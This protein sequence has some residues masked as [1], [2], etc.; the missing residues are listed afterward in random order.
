[1]NSESDGDDPVNYTHAYTA[2]NLFK[3]QFTVNGLIFYLLDFVLWEIFR[4]IC[5]SYILYQKG[6]IEIYASELPGEFN[7]RRE[8]LSQQMNRQPHVTKGRT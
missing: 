5:I 3:F 7:T 4:Y 8:Y 6:T 1:M 2:R